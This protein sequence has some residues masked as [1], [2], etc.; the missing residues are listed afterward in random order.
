M[1]VHAATSDPSARRSRCAAPPA[2]LASAVTMGDRLAC[3]GAERDGDGAIGVAPTARRVLPPG[4]RSRTVDLSRTP[5]AI[6]R[7]TPNALTVPARCA[8]E[9]VELSTPSGSSSSA[10]AGRDPT[11][12]PGAIHGDRAATR[13]SPRLRRR[14]SRATM[15]PIAQRH[16][17]HG[18]QGNGT[19]IRGDADA[20]VVGADRPAIFRRS[21]AAR[22][23]CRA[24]ARADPS[25]AT[26]EQPPHRRRRVGRQRGPVG[27]VARAPPR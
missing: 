22:R 9:V 26:L 10:R 16:D 7:R 20:I 13:R 23:R 24:A 11:P 21:R 27:L 5:P 17:R 6:A 2:Y 15:E 8:A 12:T 18:R 25:Q 1:R 4:S 19:L 14:P 3:P